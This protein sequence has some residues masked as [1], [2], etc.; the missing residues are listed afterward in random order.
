MTAELEELNER[1]KRLEFA[2]STIQRTSLIPNHKKDDAQFLRASMVCI[3][4]E[5]T[6]LLEGKKPSFYD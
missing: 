4:A 1:I 2:M 6:A 5:A 3:N